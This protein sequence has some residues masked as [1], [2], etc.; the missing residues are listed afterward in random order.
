MAALSVAVVVPFGSMGCAWR[1][2][3]YLHITGWISKHHPDWRVF[4]GLSDRDP[5]S[6]AQARN[7]GAALAGDDWDVIVFW[8]ADTVAHPD[9]VNEAVRRAHAEPVMMIAGDSHI[10]TDELSADRYLATGLMFP[11]PRGDETRSFN[12][13]GIYRR[14]CSGIVAVGRQLWDATGGYIDS[15]GGEDSHEDL[16]F[17][18]QCQIFG[19]GVQWCAGIQV[20]LWHPPA[21]RRNGHNRQV[22][23]KLANM[24]RCNVARNYVTD[25]LSTLGHRVP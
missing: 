25:Y 12:S 2:R 23:Q 18:Q 22:W 4:T 3:N 7:H 9:A 10:Y 5:F 13:Q 24:H 8:D 20:H 21:P 19:N 11:K 14:P 6:P 17:F 1:D 15:L 16:A